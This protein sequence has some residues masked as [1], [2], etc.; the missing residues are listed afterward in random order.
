MRFAEEVVATSFVPTWRSLLAHALET[1]GLSQTEI[2]GLLGITQSAVSKH[3][4]GK[5]GTDSRLEREPRLVATVE[6]VADG[7]ASRTLSAFEALSIAMALIREFETR[8][9]LCRIHEQ[10][11]PALAGL[12]CDLC[13][14]TGVSARAGEEAVLNDLR[15]ALRILENAPGVARLLPHVGSNLARAL[16]SARALEEVAA[17]PGVLYEVRGMLKVPAPPEFGVSRHVARVLLALARNAPDKLACMNLAPDPAFLDAARRAGL[18]VERVA[19]DVERAPDTLS[20]AGR[21]P[22]VFHHDGALGIEPQA[23]LVAADARALALRVRELAAGALAGR[24]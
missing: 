11:M 14:A 9:P 3:L 19:P 13:V 16:P 1:R 18:R 7:L 24:P 6:Q 2:A 5:L 21:V 23:Y 22:D 15:A 8:G 17:V 10:E 20:F 12:G 4:T